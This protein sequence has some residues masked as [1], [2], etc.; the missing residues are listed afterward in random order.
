MAIT[1]TND[2][3]PKF[4]PKDTMCMGPRGIQLTNADWMCDP[5]SSFGFADHGNARHVYDRL[6]DKSMPP[7]GSWSQDWLNTYQAWMTGGFA[8]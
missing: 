8:R 3:Q 6:N 4:R 7:D 2:I 5:G 1:Y